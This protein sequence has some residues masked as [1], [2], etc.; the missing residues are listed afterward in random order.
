VIDAQAILE[1][2][3]D[4]IVTTIE[5]IATQYTSP[6]HWWESARTQD[7]APAWPH[8]P[9]SRRTQARDVAFEKMAPLRGPEGA[10]TRVIRVGYTTASAG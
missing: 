4:S 6:V 7:L 8:I 1:D 9:L 10:L 2:G 3:Y 5:Q